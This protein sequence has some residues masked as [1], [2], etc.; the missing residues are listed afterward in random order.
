MI[1]T[2]ADLKHYI[3]CDRKALGLPEKLS[4]ARQIKEFFMPTPILAYMITLRKL[5]YYSNNQR[6]YKLK[7]L[8]GGI[9]Y[10]ICYRRLS[11]KLGL[12]IPLNAFGPGLKIA[13]IGGIIVNENVK[14]G[15][16]CSIRPYTVIGNKQDGKNDQVPIIGD[17]VTIGC[18]VSIIGKIKIGNDAVIGAG[19]V[20]VKDVPNGGVVVGNPAKLVRI[21][22]GGEIK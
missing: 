6:F 14:V 20:V 9:Y 5:E 15:K 2:K 19:S 13:H 16:C 12:K 3:E 22:K 10:K 8:G 17:N 7:L 4:F 11:I 18:N 1:Q 21:N